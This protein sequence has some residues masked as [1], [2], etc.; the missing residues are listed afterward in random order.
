LITWG[1]ARSRKEKI[2]KEEAGV[3][4]QMRG[5]LYVVNGKIKAPQR[6]TL[7]PTWLLLLSEKGM[8]IPKSRQ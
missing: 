2:E 8:E 7:I 1:D 5:R 4:K 3:T 6:K